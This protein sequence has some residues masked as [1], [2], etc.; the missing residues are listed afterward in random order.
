MKA[1][2]A[3]DGEHSGMVTPKERRWEIIRGHRPFFIK[4]CT[5]CAGLCVSVANHI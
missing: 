3:E 2:K 1:Q 5:V 4:G